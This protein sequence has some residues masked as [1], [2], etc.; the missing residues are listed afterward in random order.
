MIKY[1]ERKKKNHNTL[2]HFIIRRLIIKKK[3]TYAGTLK[4]NITL[5]EKKLYTTSK[6]PYIIINHG[7]TQAYTT[8]K[9]SPL[10]SRIRFGRKCLNLTSP[11]IA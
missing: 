10:C 5:I 11:L 6:F 8:A 1:N 3:K 7:N 4:Y 2:F 9:R